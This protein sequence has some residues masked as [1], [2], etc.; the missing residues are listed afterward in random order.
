ML[1]N[2]SLSWARIV[3]TSS[4]FEGNLSYSA[5]RCLAP[6]CL[7]VVKL[8]NE[9]FGLQ[10]CIQMAL[11]KYDSNALYTHFMNLII[12]HF[13]QTNIVKSC[14]SFYKKIQQKY[15]GFYNLQSNNIMIGIKNL[16]NIPEIY[17]GHLHQN[18]SIVLDKLLK[19]V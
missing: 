7:T 2:A 17:H 3:D 11:K 19:F 6:I 16:N 8:F 5:P 9:L 4:Q 1:S 12:H 18:F 10:I 14:A 13:T 15:C